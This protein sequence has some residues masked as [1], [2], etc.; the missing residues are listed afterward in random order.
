M[1]YQCMDSTKARRFLELRRENNEPPLD[2]FVEAKGL[3]IEY[4]IDKINE[5]RIELLKLKSKYPAELKQRDE[6]GGRFEAEAC[7]IVHRCLPF[8]PQAFADPH[9]WTW[10]A[11]TQLSE[12]VEWRH[13]GE[14]RFAALP[15]YGVGSR[16]ESL[17]FRMWLRADLVFDSS[18][19][20]PYWLAKRGD[21][22]LW[23]SHILRQGYAS[24]RELA[25]TLV[26]FQCPQNGNRL[27]TDGIRELAKRIRRLRA[28]IMFEFLNPGQLTNILTEQANGL[29]TVGGAK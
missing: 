18:A 26:S 9:F 4:P 24:V 6:N 28:N 20:D 3:G 13:G 23:R 7:E 5:L 2:T 8:D 25:K 29:A 15:N 19:K 27:T 10:L 21:Q 1:R 11:V 17:I 14:G 16:I 12:I 22:D